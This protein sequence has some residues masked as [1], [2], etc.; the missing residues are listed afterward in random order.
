MQ[1]DISQ[2]YRHVSAAFYCSAFHQREDE[3]C[4]ETS[5][6]MTEWGSGGGGGIYEQAEQV[7]VGDEWQDGGFSEQEV[8]ML[9]VREQRLGEGKLSAVLIVFHCV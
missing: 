1:G 5:L 7:G 9:L 6:G 3:E 8:W 2:G 4:D